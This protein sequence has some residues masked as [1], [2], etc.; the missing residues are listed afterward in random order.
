MVGNVGGVGSPSC[1]RQLSHELSRAQLEGVGRTE[2]LP[3]LRSKGRVGG[4]EE[5]RV[6]GRE[7]ERERERE[8]QQAKESEREQE[9]E[10]KTGDID[11]GDIG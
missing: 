11:M 3:L 4:R 9:R 5:E 1:V 6:C 10:R 2:S 8:R 7:S